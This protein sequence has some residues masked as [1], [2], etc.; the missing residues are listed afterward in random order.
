MMGS[1]LRCKQ[2]IDTQALVE[3]HRDGGIFERLE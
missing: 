2:R 3:P 1:G